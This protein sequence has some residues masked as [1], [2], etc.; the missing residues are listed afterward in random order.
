M[1]GQRLD[2]V[3]EEVVHVVDEALEERMLDADGDRE[4]GEA[5]TASRGKGG[6]AGE[7]GDETEG[8]ALVVETAL[9]TSLSGTYQNATE[10][11]FEFQPNRPAGLHLPSS[12]SKHNRS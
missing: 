6:G 4:Y 8:A 7:G 10:E 1:R 3:G 12:S 5:E 9:R 2:A 11:K